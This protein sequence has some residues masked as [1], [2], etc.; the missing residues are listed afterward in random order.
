MSTDEE[1][2]DPSGIEKQI[3]VVY[4]QRSCD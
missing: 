1:I 3:P 4:I 2:A